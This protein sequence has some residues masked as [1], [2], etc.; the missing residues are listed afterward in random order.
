VKIAM[1]RHDGRTAMGAV[2]GDAVFDLGIADPALP[3][4]IRS[5]LAAGPS[6]LDAAR[7][8][9]E[10]AVDG[11]P[12]AEVRLLAPIPRPEKFLGIGLNYRAHKTT[13]TGAPTDFSEQIWFN[14]QVSC[15]VG[16]HDPMHVPRVSSQF[17]YEVELAVV[18]GR[19]CRHVPR[20]RAHE[21]IAGYMVTNDGSVRDWQKRAPTAMLG[22]SFDTHGPT[23]PWLTT[24]DE[25]ADPHA[26]GLRTWVNGELRQDGNTRDMVHRIDAQIAH[27]S[28]VFTL[29]PGDILATGTCDG[30]GFLATP[31]F[32]LK[33]GDVVRMEIDGLGHIEN[34]VILEPTDTAVID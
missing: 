9:A 31:P 15:I 33:A 3:R 22:K 5:L 4:D 25:I 7:A 12:L 13:L 24:A 10:R 6:A 18:I 8:A 17:D 11:V 21:V 16:P 19:R 32:W 2:R 30:V 27:L 23:G 26:L 1:F 20:E 14:K 28:T 29:E 34:R